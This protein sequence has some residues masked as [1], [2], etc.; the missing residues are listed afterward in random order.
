MRKHYII[1]VLGV[2]TAYILHN[3]FWNSLGL[4]EV[5]SPESQQ[6]TWLRWFQKSGSGQGQVKDLLF[7][8]SVPYGSR[9]LPCPSLPLGVNSLGSFR[10]SCAL[11]TKTPQGFENSELTPDHFGHGEVSTLFHG[12][13]SR[14]QLHG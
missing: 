11:D 13:P 12:R 3:S 4:S 10:N 9:L 1:Q 8:L 14:N 7:I 5:K 6:G 2:G